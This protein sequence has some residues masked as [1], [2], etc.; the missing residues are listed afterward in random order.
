MLTAC[1][2]LGCWGGATETATTGAGVDSVTAAVEDEAAVE[3]IVEEAWGAAVE[4][5]AEA[6]ADDFG[7][8]KTGFPFK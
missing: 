8:S 1:C 3:G 4:L 2:C 6:A 7:I 5:A